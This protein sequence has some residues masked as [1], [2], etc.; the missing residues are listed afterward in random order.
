M[1]YDF[2]QLSSLDFEELCRDLLQAEFGERI[3]TFKSGKDKGIDARLLTNHNKKTIIQCK[4]YLKSGIKALLSKLKNEEVLKVRKLSPDRYIFVTSLPLSPTNKEDI[5]DIFKPYIRSEKDIYGQEDLNNLLNLYPEIQTQHFKL[6]LTSTK[7]LDKL[8]NNAIENRTKQL[9]N[10]LT[11]NFKLYVQNDSFYDLEKLINQYHISIISGEPGVGKTTL[12]KITLYRFIDEGFLPVFIT[13][14]KDAY[15]KY[16]PAVPT[17]YYFDDFLGLTY[18]ADNFNDNEINDIVRLIELIKKSKNSRMILTSREFILKQATHHSERF[19]NSDFL[20]TKYKLEI[21]NYTQTMKA[22]ILYNHLYFSDLPQQHIDQLIATKSYN[23][24]IA[25][26]NYSPRIIQWMTKEFHVSGT[27][28]HE[29]PKL[30]LETLNNPSKLWDKPFNKQISKAAQNILLSLLTHNGFADAKC[31]QITFEGV[32]QEICNKYNYSFSCTDYNTAVEEMLGS[33]IST[34]EHNIIYNNP[35]VKDF[36]ENWIFENS[37]IFMDIFKSARFLKQLSNLYKLFKAK[38]QLHLLAEFEDTLL[39]SIVALDANRAVT[40]Q[41]WGSGTSYSFYDLTY[42]SRVQLYCDLLIV[43]GNLGYLKLIKNNLE[44]SLNAEPITKGYIDE[45]LS[46]GLKINP[47]FFNNLKD[48]LFPDDLIDLYQQIVINFIAVSCSQNDFYSLYSIL[49]CGLIDEKYKEVV[50]GE[51]QNFI[52]TEAINEASQIDVIE[53]VEDYTSNMQEIIK[54]FD[55]ES[56]GII[57]FLES[58]KE[59]LQEDED[60]RYVNDDGYELRSQLFSISNELCPIDAMFK[61]LNDR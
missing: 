21:S 37:N 44:K 22:R 36:I 58:Q 60:V 19:S 46:L 29:Y 11:E 27:S 16:N 31:L 51:F 18:F 14:A 15:D 23:S 5:Y 42:C 41:T 2:V 9:I 8:L 28:E 17:I 54:F 56:N 10:E 40:I 1:A 47:H 50:K 7:V 3:E 59:Q 13:N 53:D 61:H 57:E 30:F 49:D 12:A 33:F 39:D 55:V 4:H 52:A 34:Q 38:N 6:W 20:N 45:W 35:S 26:P 48:H 25:H 43:S 32:H 24:I